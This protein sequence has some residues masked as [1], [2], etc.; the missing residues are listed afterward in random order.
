MVE[1][2]DTQDLGSCLRGC[3]F[4]SCQRHLL[5]CDNGSQPVLK[6]GVPKGIGGSSPSASV[7][8]VKKLNLT[9]QLI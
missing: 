2:A 8:T 6:T 4:E 3:R 1:L 5:V 7:L 9:N